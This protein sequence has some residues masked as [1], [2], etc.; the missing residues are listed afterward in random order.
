[1]PLSPRPRPAFC[2]LLA[3]PTNLECVADAHLVEIR[4]AHIGRVVKLDLVDARGGG[5]FVQEHFAKL[6][7]P[8]IGMEIERLE[9]EGIAREEQKEESRRHM[10]GNERRDG[11]VQTHTIRHLRLPS[12]R[13]WN[14]NDN[15]GDQV[16]P[17]RQRYRSVLPEYSRSDASYRVT[18]ASA[19][20]VTV[21]HTRRVVLRRRGPHYRAST[22]PCPSA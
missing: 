21:L 14:Q 15:A 18:T 19:A 8:S 11:R 9:E 5:A 7:G 3:V 12:S 22:R 2:R 17:H 20:S 13:N 4:L 6:L 1:M 10:H 16:T